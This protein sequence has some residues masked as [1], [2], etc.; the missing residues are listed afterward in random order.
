MEKKTWK[1]FEQEKM[2]KNEKAFV[3]EV[4]Y[5]CGNK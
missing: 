5:L 3:V 2:K 1:I 4:K